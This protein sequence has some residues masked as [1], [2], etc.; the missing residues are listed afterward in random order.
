MSTLS[1]LETQALVAFEKIRIVVLERMAKNCHQEMPVDV[2]QEMLVIQ[3]IVERMIKDI[4][5][6]K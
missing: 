2:K 6:C 1:T 4:E 3:S 5:A